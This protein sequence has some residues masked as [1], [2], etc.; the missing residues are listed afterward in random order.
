MAKDKQPSL[1]Y[2]QKGSHPFLIGAK[3]FDKL[4]G[5]EPNKTYR[6]QRRREAKKLRELARKAQ[7]P[8]RAM[9]KSSA[10]R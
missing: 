3:L 5:E 9:D 8:L 1:V 4:A 10:K 6:W 7:E 2:S